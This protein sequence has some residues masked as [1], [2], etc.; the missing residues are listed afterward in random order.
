MKDTICLEEKLLELLKE[1]ASLNLKLEFVE[2]E[3]DEMENG[4]GMQC[5][6]LADEQG[7][8]EICV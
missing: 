2:V 5:E 1:Q 7:E 6:R 8:E 4:A 3:G